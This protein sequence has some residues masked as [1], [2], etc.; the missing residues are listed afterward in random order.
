M[1]QPPDI[2]FSTEDGVFIKQ[3]YLR[4]SGTVVPQHSHK[5]DHTSMLAVGAIAVWCDGIYV[6]NFLA[7]QPIVIKA[8]KKH[9]FMSLIDHT[10]LYC[11][12]NISRTG[13]VEVEDEHIL[14]EQSCPGVTLQEPQ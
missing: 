6:G 2:S 8:G 10:M 14:G 7:P 3:M 4:N 1:E 13:D 11:I 5:Y 12:H 9:T